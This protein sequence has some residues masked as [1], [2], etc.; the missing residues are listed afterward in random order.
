V[1]IYGKLGYKIFKEEAHGNKVK[2]VFF[3]KYREL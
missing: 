1:P 3:E 2:L